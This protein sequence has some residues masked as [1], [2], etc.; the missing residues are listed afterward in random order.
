MEPLSTSVGPL[1]PQ[2]F[3]ASQVIRLTPKYLKN[4]DLQSIVS[5]F[6]DFE[7]LFQALSPIIGNI[8]PE[9]DANWRRMFLKHG[10][11]FN[12]LVAMAVRL[13]EQLSR[14]EEKPS[15]ATEL[16]KVRKELEGEKSSWNLMLTTL[17]TQI[18]SV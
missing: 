8:H 16:R 13:A 11:R 18:S 3:Q 14:S 6:E 12:D 4:D 10:R 9:T 1:A 15:I 7:G 17:N 5:Q 2:A